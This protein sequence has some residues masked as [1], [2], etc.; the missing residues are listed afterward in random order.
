PGTADHGLFAR[1]KDGK[2]LVYET[3]TERAVPAG[4]KGARPALSRRYTLEDGRKVVPSFELLANEYLDP[5]HAA[6]AVADTIGIS[7]STIR[8]L[9][10]EIAR[11]AFEEAIEIDQPWTDIYGERHQTFV[12]RP[13]SFHAMRGISAHSN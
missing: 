8:G 9:A 10:A 13:V 3:V 6:D 7:T 4:T 1:D 12:G 2:T 5:R 11:V